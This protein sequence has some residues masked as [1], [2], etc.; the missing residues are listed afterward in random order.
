MVQTQSETL[1]RLVQGLL[2]VAFIAHNSYTIHSSCGD[3]W[4]WAILKS[5]GIQCLSL[6]LFGVVVS[7]LSYW[8]NQ[9]GRRIQASGGP[10][11][12]GNYTF[13]GDIVD[14]INPSTILGMTLYLTLSYVLFTYLTKSC[15]L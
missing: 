12:E 4:S 6:A 8:E 1:I 2:L 13:A 7:A 11:K 9:E 14:V 5:L 3:G 10:E 15:G